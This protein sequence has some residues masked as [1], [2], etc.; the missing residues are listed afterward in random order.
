MSEPTTAVVLGGSLA[1]M[2]AARALADVADRVVVVERDVLPTGPAPRKGLPQARHVHQLWSGGARALEQLL[3]GVTGMLVDAGA[4]RQKVTTDMVVLS[5]QGW[6]RRWDESH[7]MLL[8]SRDLLDATVRAEALAHPHIELADGTEALAL[9]GTD[10]A[11]TGVRLRGSD[12]AERSLTADLVVDATGRGSR[13][14]QRLR[15]FGLPEPERREVDSG[16]A[17]ASRIYRAP[18]AARDGFPVV[19]IQPDPRTGQPGRGGVLLPIEGGQWL[20]TLY[21][22]QGGEPSTDAADFERYAREELRHPVLADLCGQAE[23]LGEPSFT[24]TTV[25]RRHY[26]ERMRVW[27]EGLVV[28][29]DALAAFNPVYGHGMS[30]AAQSAVALRAAVRRRGWGSRAL[31]RLAQRA[32]ARPVGAA[33]ELAIGQDVFYPGA[34]QNGP[35]LRERAVAAYVDR[36]MHTATGNGRVAK[37][38]TDVTSLERGAEMLLTPGML[39]AAMV[40]PLKPALG[41]PPL[42]AEERKAA[43]LS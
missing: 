14:P 2:L 40:G 38:V 24:R 9:L 7:F 19:S 17:Y 4:H 5:P 22:T 13:T 35:T 42:T 23:P 10:T 29:G 12:G 33:W 31:A 37:R 30:V 34:T 39:L 41:R 32:V 20:V 26:Y 11:I 36:L 43:G 3:P 1:G 18:E 6:F 16:L 21:G 25:N 8:C 27:P 28:L 15:E